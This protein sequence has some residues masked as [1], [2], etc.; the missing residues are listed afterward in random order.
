MATEA[1]IV[2]DWL[3]PYNHGGAGERRWFGVL[4]GTQFSGSF[5]L[6]RGRTYISPLWIGLNTT[7][8]WTGVGVRV[9]TA[10]AGSNVRLGVFE[11][12]EENGFIPKTLL[13][14]AGT[15]TGAATGAQ[16]A[17]I[18]LTT[19]NVEWIGIAFMGESSATQPNLDQLNSS[20]TVF[21]PLLGY[22]TNSVSWQT[23]SSSIYTMAHSSTVSDGAFPDSSEFV[24]F[25]PMANP[26][27]QAFIRR[28][29][30]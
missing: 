20:P 17:T 11:L 3:Q 19:T 30:V 2:D 1:F 22:N 13:L 12:D 4:S 23:A 14:D 29:T 21:P 6:I 16:I 24:N 8:N 18:S 7:K 27:P 15:V 26:A 25:I 10:G 9:R 5:T 28:S